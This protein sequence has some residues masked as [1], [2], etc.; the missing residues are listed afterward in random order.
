[1]C[2][3]KLKEYEKQSEGKKGKKNKVVINWEGFDMW[4][5]EAECRN[6]SSELGKVRMPKKPVVSQCVRQTPDL[7]S[8]SAPPRRHPVQA[9][10]PV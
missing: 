5:T 4:K 3:N 2:E 6:R 1:M 9:H 8:E 10:E 7:D